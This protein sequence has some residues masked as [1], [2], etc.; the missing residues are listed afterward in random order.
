MK[1]TIIILSILLGQT[2]SKGAI[3][4]AAN[5]TVDA[6]NAAIAKASDGDTVTVPIGTV[7]WTSTL[8]VT[9][10][11]TL[12]GAGT[13]DTN[14]GTVTDATVILDNLPRN[15]TQSAII[16]ATLTPNQS[17]RL[18]GFTFRPGS[19][20]PIANNGAIRLVGT[21]PSVRIDHCHFDQ[22]YQ[23]NQIHTYSWLYGVIDHCVI[24]CRGSTFS[25]VVWH[26]TW[27]NQSRGDGSWAEPSYWGSGKFIFI[28]NN[29]IRN[30]EPGG[31]QTNACIDAKMGGRYVARYNKFYNTVG[32]DTHGT[33]GAPQRS[34]R[35][36]ESYHN[37]FNWTFSA[38][39]GQ[40][41]GGTVLFHDN[42]YLGATLNAGP[43][44]AVYREFTPFAGFGGANGKNP[45]DLN[46]KNAPN[47]GIVPLGG[48][49]KDPGLYATGKHAGANGSPSLVVSGS[50][51]KANQWIGYVVTNLDQP[52]GANVPYCNAYV[53]SNTSNRIAFPPNTTTTFQPALAFNTGDR[54]EIR[55]VIAAIDQPGRGQGDLTSST[56][57]PAWP[58]QA[59]DPI[60]SWNNKQMPDNTNVDVHSPSPSVR[61]NQEYYNNTVKPG[62]IPY[63][64]PHPLA[65]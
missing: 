50:P 64:Y 57:T 28:E 15:S 60:Y 51:W 35:A 44:L 39:G 49:V 32:P 42:I 55:K 7:S 11:I 16:K 56:S 63:I 8:N 38:N 40:V 52:H 12:K 37:T 54:F 25:V 29:I 9:K 3:W 53:V 18:T 5:A 46:D 61:E 10:G 14:A 30:V 17:F 65:K 33:E 47:G 36:F 4:Q 26:N 45:W 2:I 24:D 58:N 1:S 48:T 27:G 62:Y 34:V 13:T 59:L 23:A 41:R 19:I 21:C 6:I 22:L 31:K 20:T 43:A